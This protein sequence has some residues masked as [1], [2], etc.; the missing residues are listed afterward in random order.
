MC[1]CVCVQIIAPSELGALQELL[2]GHDNT[3]QGPAWHLEQV[4]VTDVRTGQVSDTH[5]HIYAHI[6]ICTHT[7]MHTCAHTHMRAHTRTSLAGSDTYRHT[8]Q[9]KYWFNLCVCVCVSVCVCVCVYTD[10]VLRLQSV[11]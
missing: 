11:V 2:I 10:V 5:T 1:V 3:G 9:N 6:L 8:W 4:D 7:H